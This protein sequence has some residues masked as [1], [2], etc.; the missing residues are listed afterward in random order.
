MKTWK[1]SAGVRAIGASSSV[2]ASALAASVALAG[3][4]NTTWYG[5]NPSILY[6][7]QID[8]A[9]GN[10]KAMILETFESETRA[11][12]LTVEGVNAVVAGNSVA[13]DGTPGRS[14][15]VGT[16]EPFNPGSAILKFNPSD[17]GGAPRQVGFV[18][19]DASGLGMPQDIIVTVYYADGSAPATQQFSVLSAAEDPT[20]DYF[21]GI[22]DEIGIE[23]VVISS[24]APISIDHV[25]Y[26]GTIA[27]PLGPALPDDFDGDGKSE[28]AW[29]R[30]STKQAWVWSVNGAATSTA[31]TNL[32]PATS[33]AYIVGT[34]D[35]NADRKADMLWYDPATTTLSLWQMN[36]ATASSQ[37]ISTTA[38]PSWRPIAYTDLDGNGRADIVFHR[39]S[40]NRT[41]IAVW[42]MNGAT[43]LSSTTTILNGQYPEAFVGPV[44]S[45]S[46]NNLVLRRS[47]GEVYTAAFSGSSVVGLTRVVNSVGT[48]EPAPPA[49]HKILGLADT[50]GDGIADIVWRSQPGGV[51]YWHMVGGAK[52]QSCSIISV[53][54]SSWQVGGFPDIDGDRDRDVLLRSVNT[55]SVRYLKMQGGVVTSNNTIGNASSTWKNPTLRQ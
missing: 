10:P 48:N 26:D 9:F 6:G 37:V 46:S 30:Q 49:S 19:T 33:T 27:A 34:A 18:V 55:G 50:S 39:I 43:R 45:A 25:Q 36:A 47:T 20:D 12:G 41:L 4:E 7:S 17:I 21:I 35:S 53:L 1:L 42:M 2:A 8:S 15:A 38:S 51:Y 14:L 5:S 16:W 24:I 32:R 11:A 44:L 52:S 3:G 23:Q 54:G 31:L 29:F 13:F 28:I 40:G 22:A